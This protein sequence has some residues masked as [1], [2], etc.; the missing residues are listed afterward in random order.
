M[1]EKHLYSYNTV[2]ARKLR[3]EQ[4][5]A[6]EL[7]WNKLRDRRLKGEKFKRQ[8]SMDHYITDF[9]CYARRLIVEVDGIIHNELDQKEYDKVREEKLKNDGFTVI[10]FNNEDVF[11]RLEEVLGEIEKFLG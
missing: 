8:H 11:N 5:K 7:L 2:I 6:E 9:Y 1:Q 4:T 3:R 10:R